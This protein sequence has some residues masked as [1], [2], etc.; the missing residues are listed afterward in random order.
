[1]HASR[2][3]I[4]RHNLASEV[5]EGEAIIVDVASGTYFSA[6]TSGSEVWSHLL[7]QPSSPAQLVARLVQRYPDEAPGR[8]E[9]DL[10]AFITTLEGHGLLFRSDDNGDAAD[11]APDSAVGAPDAPVVAPDAAP[12]TVSHPYAPPHLEV[13]TDMRDFLLVD[14]I[15]EVSEGGFPEP[16]ER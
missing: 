14:P 4:R 1:M 15:H 16:R 2:I 10:A 13:F 7:A 5:I 9:D 12:R 6:N 8:L 11:A 3:S